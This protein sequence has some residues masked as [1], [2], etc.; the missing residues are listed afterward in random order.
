MVPSLSPSTESW[1]VS[2]MFQLIQKLYP[3]YLSRGLHVCSQRGNKCALWFML[4]LSA[5][6]R[7]QRI[8]VQI[9]RKDGHNYRSETAVLC[10]WPAD[11][12]C[13]WCSGVHLRPGWQP[14]P[15]SQRTHGKQAFPA[16]PL[17]STYQQF[18]ASSLA[19]LARSCRMQCIVCPSH[20]MAPG[21]HLVG[22][23]KASSSGAPVDKGC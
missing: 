6:V 21:L 20:M 15:C 22:Q 17:C 12:C 7:S 10:R 3:V 16:V 5:L 23:T 19:L 2:N 4:Q 18:T 1:A 8:T 13:S 11:R 9:M 14:S